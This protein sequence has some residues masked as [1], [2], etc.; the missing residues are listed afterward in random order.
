MSDSQNPYRLSERQIDNI[1]QG[2]TK[3]SMDDVMD[4]ETLCRLTVREQ[5]LMRRAFQNGLKLGCRMAI[6]ASSEALADRWDK[7]H[8]TKI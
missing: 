4:L 7:E 6:I 8:A 3:V 5:G 1:T 2:V